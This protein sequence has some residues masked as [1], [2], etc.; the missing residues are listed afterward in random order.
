MQNNEDISSY[1]YRFCMAK[2]LRKTHKQTTD[3]ITSCSAVK[4]RFGSEYH[5]DNSQTL[6]KYKDH[7]TRNLA[8][9]A[10]LLNMVMTANRS[11][12]GC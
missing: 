8:T 6:S 10:A 9:T 12:Q 4:Y 1:V 7:L 2:L 11:Q 3:D 5:T